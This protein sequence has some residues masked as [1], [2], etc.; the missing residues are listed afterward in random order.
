[1][2]IGKDLLMS[3]IT[4][5][6]G[7]AGKKAWQRLSRTE[8]VIWMLE[9]FNIQNL[10]PGSDFKDIYA[11]TL[12]EY[13]VDQPEEL[14]KFFRE[15]EIRE[16]FLRAFEE[17]NPGILQREAELFIPWKKTGIELE[18]LS[19][20]PRLEFSRFT[21]IFNGLLR[22]TRTPY[23]VS[24][25]NVTRC[26]RERVDQIYEI[27]SKS[28][29]EEVREE[30]LEQ[31]RGTLVERVSEWFDTLGY[32]RETGI[33]RTE[34]F[35]EMIIAVTERRG[36]SRILVRC[37]Q[38]RGEAADM[39]KLEAAVKERNLKEGWLV[40]ER[41][42]AKGACGMDDECRDIFCYTFDQLLDL[43]ADF[44]NYF[45][46]L[47][48][49][50][51]ERGVDELYI[52]LACRREVGD[53]EPGKKLD[54]EVYGKDDGWLT[55][56][57]DR[58]LQDATM[59]HVSILGEF[60]TGKTWFS[61]HYAYRAM[62]EYREKKA[63]GLER[64]RLPVVVQLRD[65]AKQLDS[66]SL[67]SDFFFRK[68]KIPLPHYLA[69]EYLNRVGKLV[70][71]FDGFDEMADKLD[72]QKM[73][74]NFWELARVVVPGSKAVLTCRNEHFPEAREGR[75][76]LQAELRAS[77]SALS[78]EP[79]QFEVLY[80]EPF[81]EEQIC[82]ALS[83]RTEKK[84]TVDYIMGHP[85][86][87]D[88][89]RR[90]VLLE[91]IID[92]LPEIEAG[93]P[94]DLA[95]IY[96]YAVTK[97]LETDF[98]TGRT[99]TSPADRL[100]FMC[101][102]SYHMLS[103]ETL[104]LNYRAFPGR[105]RQLFGAEVGDEK[106]LDFWKYSMMGN[107]L[108]VRNDDGDYSPAHK[109][110]TE[111]FAAFK[112]AACMGFLPPDFTAAAGEQSHID[113][114]RA[115]ESYSW[116]CYF[117]R[118][119]D[120]SGEICKIA[121]LKNFKSGDR[122]VLLNQLVRMPKAVW[123]FLFDITNQDTVREE[124]YAYLISVLQDF[125]KERRDPAKQQDIIQFI[126]DFRRLSREWAGGE[127]R[128]CEVCRIWREYREKEFGEIEEK[129][130]IITVAPGEKIKSIP[131]FQMASIPAGSFLMGSN[132]IERES[133]IHRVHINRPFLLGTTPVTNKFY[134]AVIGRLPSR[135]EGDN[136]PVE[137]V[138]RLDAVSFCNRLSGLWGFAPAYSIDGETVTP[139][140][141]ADGFRLPTEA[142]WEY[143][144]R[145]GSTDERYVDLDEI[146]WY[147]KNS[148]GSTRPVAELKPNG[149]G[150]Y[151]MLGNVYEWCWDRFGSYPMN[152]VPDARG[153]AEGGYRVIRGG[154]WGDV[155][156]N[157]RAS[158]R[159]ADHP[160]DRDGDLGFRL[161]R[162]FTP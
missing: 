125:K 18:K 116:D 124:F 31:I 114:G 135:F 160:G 65:Y 35:W 104:S 127:N 78:A 47:E 82:L 14:L 34:D 43:H 50:V 8:K 147:G 121:P 100:F 64:P 141:E 158:F 15:K 2:T 136:H 1:M 30:N 107:T 9:K 67:F 145:A 58:W 120:E 97:K 86:L 77:V 159:S 83:R 11:H 32:Q 122:E 37:F 73:I 111:F 22:Q 42:L 38:R 143:A 106:T 113:W 110:L 88:M 138:S 66:Q 131:S 119:A 12:V 117:R 52:P 150:M 6:I 129:P 74:D 133:P 94:V 46:W 93:K 19:I 92:A 148:G 126:Y 80:L 5:I 79:P 123:R 4:G 108:L 40:A 118:E 156:D 59:E 29:L 161:A 91:Y 72:R 157:C 45:D 109:S 68:H 62:L 103:T 33:S 56:Y 101:E 89:A 10:G 75:K 154:S 17:N 71:I 146:A 70:L 69:F 26:L 21:T 85:Q 149:W 54:D 134:E 20:N 55:G 140:W 63:K 36:V 28:S 102:L 162:S 25:D 153:A 105:L 87:A 24:H 44:S 115:P 7:M 151:D 3:V 90:P 144:C 139:D 142:E 13:G 99:F 61:L 53:P 112:L 95:R 57:M 76:L 96:L 51:K 130:A 16:A 132:L 84:E 98:K 48:T 41:S 137:K 49:Q 81:E 155:P 152:E 60:G 39:E 128:E 27:V 23:E